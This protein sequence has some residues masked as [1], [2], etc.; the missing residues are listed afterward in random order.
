MNHGENNVGSGWTRRDLLRGFAAVPLLPGIAEAN[1]RGARR[2]E[3]IGRLICV[4]GEPAA[5]KT[6][7]LTLLTYQFATMG[8]SVLWVGVGPGDSYCYGCWNDLLARLYMGGAGVITYPEVTA[9]GETAAYESMGMAFEG[10][11]NLPVRVRWMPR[12]GIR[13]VLAV[14]EA[15][16]RVEPARLVILDGYDTR[17][18]I[19]AADGKE[20]P[21]ALD[22][23]RRAA[24][25][26]DVLISM[27]LDEDAVDRC[28]LPAIDAADT[29]VAVR[30]DHGHCLCVVRTD[31]LSGDKRT[32][33]LPWRMDLFGPGLAEIP[34]AFGLAPG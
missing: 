24:A 34:V 19:A 9:G 33:E 3:P 7:L 29:L 4:G 13:E 22:Q 23:L 15:C 26:A 30:A 28:S 16:R 17:D 12:A 27:T 31:P 5:G 20:R 11:Y 10:L 1:T 14:V 2:P 25:P 8:A 6:T 18:A 21:T 32:F